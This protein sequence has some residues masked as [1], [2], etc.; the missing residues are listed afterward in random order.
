MAP[1]KHKRH[2][3]KRKRSSTN[4]IM[5]K[6]M[7][8]TGWANSKPFFPWSKTLITR[9]LGEGHNPGTTVGAIFVLPVNNWN[10]PLGS[11]STLGAGTG[12]LTSNRHPMHHAEAIEGRYKRVQVLSWKADIQVNW[13][14]TGVS[15]GDFIVAYNFTQG[16]N[17]ALDLTPGTAA[18]LQRLSLMTNPRWT[19]KSFNAAGGVD[20]PSTK[21]VF[22]NVPNVFK[23]CDII[24]KGKDGSGE[25]NNFSVGHVIADSNDSS[26]AP[27]IFLGCTV[28]IFSKS[29]LAMPIDSVHVTVAITQR[30]KIMRDKAAADDLK[31][32][33]PDVH[34]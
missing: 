19:I 6:R 17:S 13:I 1:A 30:V 20:G 31:E 15:T 7:G 12:S 4:S 2:A 21:H 29:G 16:G 26:N 34:A 9:T 27:E 32:G 8:L 3:Q 23:Y 24:A 28:V 10:D 14:K 18:R 22:I 11:L 25:A 33:N 5:R